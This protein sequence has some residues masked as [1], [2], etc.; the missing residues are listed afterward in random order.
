MSSLSL[1]CSVL[2]AD[3]N[4]SLFLF[5]YKISHD[6][7]CS[8]TEDESTTIW[9][10]FFKNINISNR[11]LYEIIYNNGKIKYYEFSECQVYI[12]VSFTTN[13]CQDHCELSDKNL[14]NTFNTCLLKF[15][16]A[17]VY[18]IQ[19]Y[20]LLVLI[21]ISRAYHQPV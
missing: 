9:C 1:I 16:V 20:E 7:I 2:I 18:F 5:R 14:H 11:H 12:E 13:I 10:N 8:R 21:R 6:S 3:M 17:R 15:P 19:R 4:I